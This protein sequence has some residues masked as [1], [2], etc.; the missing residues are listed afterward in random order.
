MTS[1]GER[2]TLKLECRTDKDTLSIREASIE[3]WHDM[4]ELFDWLC[5]AFGAVGYGVFERVLREGK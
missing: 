4:E 2:L 5:S 3:N 1:T